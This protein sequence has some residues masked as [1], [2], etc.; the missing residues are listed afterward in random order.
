MRYATRVYLGYAGLFAGLIVLFIWHQVSTLHEH[1]RYNVVRYNAARLS[2]GIEAFWRETGHWPRSLH[3]LLVDDGTPNWHGPYA[4]ASD[5][6]D[7]CDESG[8][9]IEYTPHGNSPPSL[10][11]HGCHKE[12]YD[13]DIDQPGR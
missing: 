7:M 9:D 6:R 2:M 4:H 1:G 3:A 13:F 10:A 8:G 5:L 12:P 11:T